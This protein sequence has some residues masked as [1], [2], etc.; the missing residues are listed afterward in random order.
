MLSARRYV[1]K[2]G[3]SCCCRDAVSYAR[4]CFETGAPRLPQHDDWFAGYSVCAWPGACAGR[5][6]SVGFLKLAPSCYRLRRPRCPDC[7]CTEE[8]MK[9]CRFDED[10]LGVVIGRMSTT[11]RRADTDQGRRAL[12]MKGDAVIGRCRRG[13]P[14]SRTW[15]RR[16]L[17]GREFSQAHLADRAAPPRRWRRH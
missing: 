2:D 17:P 8:S 10:R 4:R 14:A 1:S 3:Q 7:C 9:L 13:A 5:T 15:P 11:D 6:I 16:R 12:R